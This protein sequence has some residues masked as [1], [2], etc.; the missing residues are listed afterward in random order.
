MTDEK[1]APDEDLRLA[2]NGLLSTLSHDL[3]TPLSAIAGWLFLLESDKLD[4]S[5]KKRALEKIR[6]NVKD[7]VQLID[8]VLLLSRSLTGH[9]QLDLMPLSPLDPLQAAMD[10]MRPA[11]VAGS[12]NLQPVKVAQNGEAMADGERLRR[13]FEI[14]FLHSLNTTPPG[15]SIDI[16]VGVRDQNV[17]IVISDNGK[18]LSHTDLANVFN[19]FQKEEG[20][21]DS[22]YPGA[23]RNLLLARTL[24]EKQG[25]QLLVSSA[26][27]GFGNTFKLRLPCVDA[28]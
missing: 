17:E 23:E 6:A 11:A 10:N 8:D 28:Q 19:A 5:A 2:M 22:A 25:G 15:G 1:R 3:R 21:A 27:L 16:A 20:A 26:G 9:L 18:G 13:V 24:V 4:A 7:Q 12:V 14:V